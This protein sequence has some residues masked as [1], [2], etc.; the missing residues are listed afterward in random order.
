MAIFRVRVVAIRVARSVRQLALWRW[1]RWSPL[2]VLAF[3]AALGAVGYQLASA[4]GSPPNGTCG[5]C[6]LGSSGEALKLSGSGNVSL[7][8]ANVIVNSSS[9]P[10]VALTGSGSLKA[11]S[12]GV[13]GTASVTGSGEIENLT[14]GIAAVSDPLAGLVVPSLTVPSPVPSVSVT[15]STG[16]TVEP[17]VYKEIVDSGS[18]SL[19]LNAG[20][21]VILQKFANTGSGALTAKGVMLYLACSSY[22]TGCKAGEKGAALTLTGSG[23][24]NFTGPEAGCSPVSV[25]SD[26]N[27]TA[28]LTITGSGSQILNGVIYA[29][30]GS[31]ALTGSGGTFTIGGPIV[32]GSANIS[33]SGG[34][35][36]TGELPLTE[37][38]ALTLSG[39]PTS[40]RV[41]ET[42]TLTAT[43]SCSSKPLAGQP[44]S[45]AVTGANPHTETVTTNASGVATFSYTGRT[46]GTDTAIA[47]YTANGGSVSSKPATVTWSKAK[48]ALATKPT[49]SRVTLGEAI[50]DTATLTGGDSPIGTVSF[51]V[52]SSTD[53]GCKTPLNEKPLT[54]TL[55]GGAATSPKFTPSAPGTYQFLASYSGDQSNEAVAGTCGEA[56]EQV[57]VEGSIGPIKAQPQSQTV[58]EGASVSFTASSPANPAATVQWQVFEQRRVDLVKRHHRLRQHLK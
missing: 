17:G 18:G 9:K 19:T 12:V 2:A 11:P 45:F 21:Y 22:P 4:T 36:L 7:T 42:E 1:R 10:A 46:T 27:S 6:L 50:S 15:G 30:S 16:K 37:G 39:S 26:R 35:T 3:L 32:A 41:G 55:S 56:A 54:A 5:F 23:P 57:K 58:N 13:V 38:L 34:I 25:F 40:T 49:A 53:T 43:L 29:K 44:V 8:K 28:P 33:G 24:M 52:Y 51:N 31:L 48:P 47:S 20:I 14:T